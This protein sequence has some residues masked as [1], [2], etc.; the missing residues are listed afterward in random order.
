M[1]K[2]V[3]TKPLKF[4]DG[5]GFDIDNNEELKAIERTTVTFRIGQNVSTD[6]DVTFNQLDIT[7]NKFILES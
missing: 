5:T 2:L 6:S 7:T 1:A 4:V 3:F